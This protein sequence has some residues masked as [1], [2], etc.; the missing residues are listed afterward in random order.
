MPIVVANMY[1]VFSGG[2]C[3]YLEGNVSFRVLGFF[4]KE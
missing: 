1:R 2:K 4:C 3:L